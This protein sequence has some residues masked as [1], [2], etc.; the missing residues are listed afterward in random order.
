MVRSPSAAPVRAALSEPVAGTM[1]AGFAWG[2]LT[3]LIWAGWMVATRLGV[4][5]TLSV[6]DLTALRFGAAGLVLLP[7][8][9]RRGLALDRLGPGGLALL[10]AGAGAPYAVVAGF[11]FAFAPVHDAALIPGTMPVFVAL[12]SAALFGERIAPRRGAG[13]ALVLV[14][15]GVL[16]GASL[17]QARA[18]AQ[19]LGYGFFL[20]AAFLW[21]CFTLVVQRARLD[22]VHATGIVAV[23]SAVLFLPIYVLF[24]DTRIPEAPATDVL[25]QAVYQGLLTSIVALVAYGRVVRLLGPTR[26]AAIASLVPVAATLL[27]VPVLGEWPS[28]RDMGG[29]VLISL[30]VALATGAR[31]DVKKAA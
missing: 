4:T 27:A 16:V 14:G 3:V 15:V 10:V 5:T 18:P 20:L 12:L 19:W 25:V 1:A 21:A 29:V 30:G 8:V 31:G 6:Y 13:L 2:L 23:G 28:V 7:V 17:W 11:G 22:P 26:G 9:L 24:L